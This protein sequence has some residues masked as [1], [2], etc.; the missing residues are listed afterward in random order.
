M[1]DDATAAHFSNHH[2]LSVLTSAAPS[3]AEGAWALW[4]P[5]AGES[6]TVAGGV[7]RFGLG[8]RVGEQPHEQ[9]TR[10]DGACGSRSRKLNGK[11]D[12]DAE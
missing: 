6:G 4:K 2:C 1:P 3:Y 7:F 12:R 11:Q 9:R 8:K 10:P 5:A